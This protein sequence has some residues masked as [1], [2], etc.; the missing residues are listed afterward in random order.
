MYIIWKTD[1]R[2]IK[3]E[4]LKYKPVMERG[5]QQAKSAYKRRRA[6][7]EVIQAASNGG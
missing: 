7:P 1:A 4:C 5:R 2:I 6:L 3:R